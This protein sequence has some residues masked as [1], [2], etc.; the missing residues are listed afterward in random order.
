VVVVG[1]SF[2]IRENHACFSKIIKECE[3]S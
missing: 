3:K 2:L 1:L